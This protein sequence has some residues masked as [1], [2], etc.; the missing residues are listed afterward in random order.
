MYCTVLYFAVIAHSSDVHNMDN[1]PYTAVLHCTVLLYR[2][3]HGGT[4]RYYVLYTT[5]MDSA[6]WCCKSTLATDNHRH[7]DMDH[8]I[9]KK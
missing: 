5:G 6:V 9:G 8:S 2:A 4:P 7:T 1:V 3:I